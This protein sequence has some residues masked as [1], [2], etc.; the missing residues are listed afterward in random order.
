MLCRMPRSASSLTTAR[1]VPRMCVHKPFVQ[2]RP[3][4]QWKKGVKGFGCKSR[5]LGNPESRVPLR[6][7]FLLLMAFLALRLGGP[8]LNPRP[9][10]ALNPE[11]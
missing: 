9:V 6:C 5:P 2:R 1:G 8:T 3:P 7:G 10:R 11:S 4:V